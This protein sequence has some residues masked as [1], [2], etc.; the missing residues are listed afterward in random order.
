MGKPAV[1]AT[2]TANGY[3]LDGTTWWVTGA[4][5]ADH[6]L[7]GAESDEGELLFWIPAS[8]V[9][10]GTPGRLVALTGSKTAAVHLDGVAVSMSELVAGPTQQLMGSASRNGGTGGIQ[11]SALA[12]GVSRAAT[13]FIGEESNRRPTVRKTYDRLQIQVETFESDLIDF[14]E[15]NNRYDKVQLRHR[16][17]DL[18]LETTRSALMVS[19]GAGYVAGQ[20]PGRWCRE[21]LFFLVWSVPPV[22]TASP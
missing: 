16:A 21:A 3:L 4:G 13:R 17:N 18:V 9:R 12:L 11:T 22:R 1:T 2:K 10:V 19:K 8:E 14:A 15:G 20:A 7:V 5:H 6:I